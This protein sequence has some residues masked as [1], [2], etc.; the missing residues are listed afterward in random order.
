MRKGRALGLVAIVAVMA[1]HCGDAQDWDGYGT[2]ELALDQAGFCIDDGEGNFRTPALLDPDGRLHF[3]ISYA[4]PIRPE[5]VYNVDIVAICNGTITGVIGLD[6][7]AGI[8][9]LESTI[10]G[11]FDG[12]EHALSHPLGTDWVRGQVD[13]DA[14]AV[15]GIPV[16]PN[17]G[18]TVR[19]RLRLGDGGLN[20]DAVL[21]DPAEWDFTF[22]ADPAE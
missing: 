17:Q 19:T 20:A 3:R 6:L 22:P 18:V 14:S 1:V 4:A 15:Y 10:F 8:V 21:D 12:D 7:P 13:Y 11:T 9:N 2:L 5:E 16:L